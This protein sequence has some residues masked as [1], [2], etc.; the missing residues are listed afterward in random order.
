[1]NTIA[2]VLQIA[3]GV[4]VTVGI[5]VVLSF[6]VWQ[7]W[8]TFRQGTHYLKKLHRIPCSRCVYFTGDYRMKCAVHPMSALTEDAI[9]CVDYLA[10]APVYGE[11]VC[12]T[13]GSYCQIKQLVKH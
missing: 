10:D 1:M 7:I 6:C 8:Y 2:M 12:Q 9:D 4:G 3:V 5:C 13:V 11:N